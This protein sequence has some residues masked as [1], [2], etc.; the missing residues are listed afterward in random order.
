M[1]GFTLRLPQTGANLDFSIFP[2]IAD[3]YQ[4][5]AVVVQGSV[6][7]PAKSITV[8]DFSIWSEIIR[9]GIGEKNR[10]SN[11]K[12]QGSCLTASGE[13]NEEI[14]KAAPQGWKNPGP[15]SWGGKWTLCV[16]KGLDIDLH[17]S[18]SCAL[19]GVRAYPGLPASTQVSAR[20]IR[21]YYC[22]R[23]D[24]SYVKTGTL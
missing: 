11:A 7:F 20:L 22:E 21:S 14:L 12:G 18:R 19:P 5:G 15:F 8:R 16:S 24:P 23:T 13:T 9:S 1:V 10:C 4:R 6:P 3:G 2:L 17:D